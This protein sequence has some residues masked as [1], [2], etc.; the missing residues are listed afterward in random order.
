MSVY[1]E[2]SVVEYHCLVH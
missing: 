2:N 1:E